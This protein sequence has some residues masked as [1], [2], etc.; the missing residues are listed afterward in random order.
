MK[1]KLH[2]KCK[3]CGRK[4]TI[5]EHKERGFGPECWDKVEKLELPIEFIEI[6][7][8]GKML[9]ATDCNLDDVVGQVVNRAE[10]YDEDFVVF[11]AWDLPYST[12]STHGKF[13]LLGHRKKLGLDIDEKLP[14][15]IPIDLLKLKRRKYVP[16]AYI[17]AESGGFEIICHTNWEMKVSLLD[18]STAWYEP[19]F[20]NQSRQKFENADLSYLKKL[21]PE[22]HAIMRPIFSERKLEYDYFYDEEEIPV[23]IQEIG[24]TE[25]GEFMDEM[26]PEIEK[27]LTHGR[28]LADNQWGINLQSINNWTEGKM[29]YGFWF[30]KILD[31]LLNGRTI[32]DCPNEIVERIWYSE[33]ER[34]AFSFVEKHLE[35]WDW[36]QHAKDIWDCIYEPDYDI[37]VVSKE[38]FKKL[39]RSIR[40][41]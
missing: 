39:F 4:L 10:K 9:W 32:E 31:Y 17:Y 26:L 22:A 40:K 7:N 21:I 24:D 16:L 12:F 8:G 6:Q 1:K 35:S 19:I 41:Y 25:Y 15:H 34:I 3:S 2:D 38:C 23:S 37:S 13:I 5:A 28:S 14:N 18:A 33:S 30:E 27:L 11:S 29:T 36:I 20:T